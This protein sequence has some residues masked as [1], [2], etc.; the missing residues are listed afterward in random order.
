MAKRCVQS[1]SYIPFPLFVFYNNQKK[2]K[3]NLK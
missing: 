2:G 3:N 1:E